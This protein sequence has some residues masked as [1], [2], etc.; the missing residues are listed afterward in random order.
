MR[1]TFLSNGARSFPRSS[2]PSMT[3]LFLPRSAVISASNVAPPSR[4]SSLLLMKIL[5]TWSSTIAPRR[6]ISPA[7][8]IS[9]SGGSEI[10]K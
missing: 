10:L 9:L 1:K 3:T 5:F 8:I 4:R 6:L 7:K 2:K